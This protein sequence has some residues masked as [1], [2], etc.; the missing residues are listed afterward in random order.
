M[1]PGVGAHCH[2]SIHVRRLS[3]RVHHGGIGREDGLSHS[4]G[5]ARRV[6]V[7]YGRV[8]ESFIQKS[9]NPKSEIYNR[10]ASPAR[11]PRMIPVY[12]CSTT[13][14]CK[15]RGR[16][17]TAQST[18]SSRVICGTYVHTSTKHQPVPE[19]QACVFCVIDTS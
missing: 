15:V 4:A 18:I 16:Q 9:E 1:G 2:E 7:P 17:Y 12:I 6:N 5:N 13:P 8:K 19:R 14:Y 3:P 11:D 10:C